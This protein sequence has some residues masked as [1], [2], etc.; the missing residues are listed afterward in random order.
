MQRK[1]RILIC[2]DAHF[3]FTGYATYAKEV[4]GRLAQTGKYEIAELACAGKVNDSRCQ[5]IPWTYYANNVSKNHPLYNEFISVPQNKFGCWRFEK[6][7]LDFKPD[8]VCDIRDPWVMS[9]ELESPYRKFFHWCIMPTVDSDP[10]QEG[11]IDTFNHADSIFTYSDYGKRILEKESNNNIHVSAV[12]SPGV[13]LEIFKP[14]NNKEELRNNMG[15][16]KDVNIIG[17]IMR[18]GVRKLYPDLFE[19]FRMFIDLCYETDNKSIADRTYLYAHCSYPDS[20]WEIPQLLKEYGIGHKVIFS[21]ICEKC[22]NVSCSFFRGPKSIC[23]KCNSIS[24]KLPDTVKG[25]SPSQLASVINTFDVYIQYSVCEGFG[26]PQ[27]EAAACGVPIMTVNYSAMEDMVNKCYGIPLSVHRFFRDHGTHSHRA[28]PNNTETAKMFLDLFSVPKDMIK[29]KGFKARKVIEKDYNW[30]KTAKIWED[31]IDNIELTGLQG[32]WDTPKM[33]FN[34]RI[35]TIP[36]NFNQMTN[37]DFTNWVITNVLQEPEK[38]YS[39]FANKLI[40][41]LNFA[42]AKNGI[43]IVSFTKIDLYKLCVTLAKDKFNCELARTG[44]IDVR[45][46]DFIEYA[47]NK[48]RYLETV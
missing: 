22:G 21:Y 9:Y 42:S 30:D 34:E 44:Q 15:F 26:M 7:C 1:K 39:R 28:L 35:P 29:M 33:Q 2:N 31:H 12:A 11:W 6:T 41:D 20:G 17:T 32:K 16:M 10:Q 36:E 40:K 47:H 43:D 18:N 24:S 45:A 19:T 3:L 14:V 13:D 4:L 25:L 27:V 46:E 8:I 48:N 5:N 23:N 37:L 38:L